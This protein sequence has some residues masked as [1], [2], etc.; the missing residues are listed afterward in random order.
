MQLYNVGTYY[1]LMNAI[2]IKMS[3]YPGE[4]A[5]IIL[6]DATN[7]TYQ[8]KVLRELDIFEDVYEG[9]NAWI[10][11]RGIKTGSA[12]ERKRIIKDFFKNDAKLFIKK[13]YTDYFLGAQTPYFTLVYYAL[14]E[15]H[16]F[17]KVHLFE[18]GIYTYVLDFASECQ[19]LG[20]SHNR[21]GRHNI[22]KNLGNTYA[23]GD[24]SMY[25][26]NK[27]LK[28]V[29][30][31]AFAA[32]ED[33]LHKEMEVFRKLWGTCPLPSER[34]IFLEEGMFQDHLIA[35]DTVLLEEI[36]K[37][38]GKE[39]IIVKRHPRCTHD[40]FS[41]RGFKVLLDSSFPFEL[42]LMNPDAENRVL[43][44]L[45]STA[46]VTGS[47]VLGKY[48]PAIQLYAMRPFGEAGPHCARDNFT[49]YSKALYLYMNQNKRTLYVPKS[50]EELKETLIFIEGK[51][52]NAN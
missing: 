32:N 4:K 13:R 11:D 38:V 5:D 14:C 2:H 17:P 15:H 7:F 23:Y 40:R 16:I 39:N 42:S 47:T 12:K 27:A 48:I 50:M 52:T 22:L 37:L 44:S 41:E 10:V 8:A 30:I 6:M 18:D 46:T 24:E 3:L 21:Y 49:P 45:S 1:E 43:I 36:A 28:Y 35:S 25:F 9:Q 20:I 51:R 31:P 29:Q 33:C 19:N 26:G 34:Y